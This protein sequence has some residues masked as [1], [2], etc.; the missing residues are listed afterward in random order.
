MKRIPKVLSEVVQA[1]LCIGCGICVAQCPSGA[2]GIKWN[3]YGF[4]VP[5]LIN[6]CDWNGKCIDVC[7]FNPEPKKDVKT[8]DDIANLFLHDAN[9][10]IPEIGRYVELYAGYS[11][12]FR[13][14]GS[15]GGIA[16]YISTELLER[17]IVQHLISVK[18]VSASNSFFEYSICS[19]PEEVSTCSKTRYFP[20]TL[21]EVFSRIT[22]L[23]G[24]VAI[25]G[26][27]CFVK[28]VRLAQ[29]ENPELRKKIIFLIGIVCGGIKSRFFTEYLASKIGVESDNIKEPEFRIKN[30]DST[31]NDYMFGCKN[32][33][34]NGHK[35]TIRMKS[36]GDMWGTGL[37]KANACDFC[38]DVVGELADISLGDA[39]IE[40]YKFDGRGTNIII[41]RS[42]LSE[43]LLL[44]GVK[45]ESV[46]LNKI[47]SDEI[48]R[49]QKGS[50][51]HRQLGLSYRIKKF[52]KKGGKVPPKR[53]TNYRI[54]FFF[55]LVQYQRMRI[56]RMSLQV[57]K[58]CNNASCFD[59]KTRIELGILLFFTK[60]YRVFKK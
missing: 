35:K 11:C 21:A 50:Y 41:S 27:P 14:S 40:P 44:E 17:G 12:E 18:P 56:R 46:V 37:F 38:D 13:L 1:D 5:E 20:V 31:A 49:S 23:E 52:R 16:T 36:V 15:S 34:E 2:L 53:F 3:K 58:N 25:T 10:Y 29:F 42:Q 54:S 59:K 9:S 28:G 4:L 24:Q 60:L 57:W 33:L 47:S 7:P 30:I 26:V 43:R 22:R 6:E 48:V 39:W 19:D 32:D 55:K 51:N 45:R 8:E